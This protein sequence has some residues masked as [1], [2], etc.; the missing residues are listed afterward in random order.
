MG[1]FYGHNVKPNIA[2]SNVMYGRLYNWFAASNANFAPAGWHVPSNTEVSSLVSY[3]GGVSTAGIAMKEAGT[4]HWINPNSGDNSSGLTLIPGGFRNGTD[5][6]FSNLY[7]SSNMW[8]ANAF[9]ATNGRDY[10][11]YHQYDYCSVNYQFKIMGNAVRLIKNDYTLVSSLT[12][13]DGNT[14]RA[15]KINNQVW[16][17]DNWACTKLNDGT[18]IPNVTTAA[19]WSALSTMGYCNYNNDVGNVFK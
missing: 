18:S 6:V 2:T 10:F 16:L 5:G 12:D 14:Y 8:C 7:T 13:A 19:A 3:L 17:I 15:I 1:L 11:A 9:D 4:V